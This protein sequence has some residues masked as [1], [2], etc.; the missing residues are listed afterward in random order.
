M[1]KLLRALA[2]TAVWIMRPGMTLKSE[3]PAPSGAG[4]LPPIRRST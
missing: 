4:L 2:I 1:K 3:N